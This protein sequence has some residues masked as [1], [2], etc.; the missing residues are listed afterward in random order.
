MLYLATAA[1]SFTSPSAWQAATTRT[2][3]TLMMERPTDSLPDST[4]GLVGLVQS[5]WPDE[6]DSTKTLGGFTHTSLCATDAKGRTM[7][8]PAVPKKELYQVVGLN[9]QAW[10]DEKDATATLGGFTNTYA[11]GRVVPSGTNH[12]TLHQ[13]GGLNQQAWPSP[14]MHAH[15]H[16][17]TCMA[18]IQVVGLF[19]QAWPSEYDKAATLGGFTHTDVF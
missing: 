8:G 14:C 12:K 4:P 5:A 9:Q 11:E 16:P 18:C 17:L 19:Q 3:S 13:V 2:A 6:Y 10:P 15:V 1:L 7:P